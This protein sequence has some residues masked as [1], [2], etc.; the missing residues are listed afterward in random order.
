MSKT[1]EYFSKSISETTMVHL[2]SDLVN[3]LVKCNVENVQYRL[4]CMYRWGDSVKQSNSKAI[5]YFKLA[6]RQGNWHA[7]HCLRFH[8]NIII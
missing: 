8:Y 6:A 2:D 4:G 5:H 3:F 7:E 1:I